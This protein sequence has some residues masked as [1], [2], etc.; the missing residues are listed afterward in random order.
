MCPSGV[1]VGSLISPKITFHQRSGIY[2]RRGVP[3]FRP[4][5]QSEFKLAQDILEKIRNIIAM[6]ERLL[7]QGKLSEEIALPSDIWKIVKIYS[8]ILNPTYDIV[9]TWR[10][11]TFLFPGRYLGQTLICYTTPVPENIKEEYL[12]ITAL[13]PEEMIVHPPRMLGEIGWEINGGL[14][15]EEVLCYLNHVRVLYLSGVIDYIRSKNSIR[16]L[17]IG[18]GYGG[19]SY[20]LWKIL[21]PS[22]YYLV[23]LPESLAYSSVYLTLT[24]GLGSSI[25]DRNISTSPNPPDKGFVFMPNFLSDDLCDAGKFDLI[26]N[27]GSF[28]EMNK[29]QITHYSEVMES[30]LANDGILYDDNG[31]HVDHPVIN[32]FNKKFKYLRINKNN[33]NMRLWAKKEDILSKMKIVKDYRPSIL[34]TP[35]TWLLWRIKRTRRKWKQEC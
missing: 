29:E 12:K 19:L 10:F 2:Y 3:L 27:T 15:N 14:V 16:I 7:E 9:N 21:K 25:Y 28:G 31:D 23:D 33:Q 35:Y 1:I 8:Y 30:V 6:R 26:I 22:V 4:I 34:K 17:E 20:F 24:S 11:H 5:N 13:L 32:I 18:P